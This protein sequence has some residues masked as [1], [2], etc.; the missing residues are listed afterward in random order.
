MKLINT[1][2]PGTLRD[3]NSKAILF[4][5]NEEREEYNSRIE[6]KIKIEKEINILKDNVLQLQ[7]LR[8]EISELKNI[9]KSAISDKGI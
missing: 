2:T 3:L 4:V 8:Y 9:I 6:E 1:T 5:D 7:S